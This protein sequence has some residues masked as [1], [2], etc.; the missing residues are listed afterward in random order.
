MLSETFLV[1]TKVAELAL[2]L[3]REQVLPLPDSLWGI[4]GLLVNDNIRTETFI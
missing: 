3:V 2:E 4:R 1:M